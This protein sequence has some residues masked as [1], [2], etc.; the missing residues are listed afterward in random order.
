M[1]FRSTAA[2]DSSRKLLAAFVFV[3]IFAATAYEF[4]ELV[5]A[6]DLMGFAYVGLLAVGS[7]FVIAILNNWRNGVYLFFSWLL[8]EDLA[9][10]YLGNNMAIYFAK[11][12]LVAVVYLSFIIAVRRKKTIKIVRPPFFVAVMLL[13]WFGIMQMFNPASSTIVYG[14]LGVKLFFWYIPLYFVG[15]ALLNS[16][17]DLRRFFR[18]NAWLALIITGLGVAQS[19]IGPSF[20]NPA[21]PAEE[22]REL[23]TLYRVSPITGLSSYR[24]PSV[25]VS[26]GRYT[27][28]LLIAW[29]LMLAF[30]GY[31][32]LR[33]RRGR[34]IAFISL[35]VV[36]AA[37]LLSGSRGVF[38]WTAGEALFIVAAYLWGAPWRQREVIRVFR[39]VQ[40]A[41]L[42]IGLAVVALFF[43]FPDALFARLAIYSETLTPGSSASELQSRTWDYP[44]RNF[45]GAFNYDRWPYG[46]GIG[47][48]SL[49]VQYVAKIFHGAPMGVGV[50]SGFGALVV[51]MGI[52]GLILW[53]VMSIAI[54]VSAW[55][56][57][58]KLKGTP[59]FPIAFAIF[60]YAF[61][62][63]LPITFTSMVA[64]EDFVIN[65][66][67]WT[68][69]GILFRLPSLA[70][71][72]QFANVPAPA[73]NPRLRPR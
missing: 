3:L 48:S 45:L 44:L 73:A 11:D 37:V 10:K 36:Y 24:A 67:F 40:R 21:R 2:P 50:E 30:T 27:N 19:I 20:L 13:V 8:F 7:V 47:T 70:L 25:F 65:A 63:L 5:L 52:G 69:L 23:S 57:V 14:I 15:Y 53:L 55:K 26:A 17:A 42:A 43:V 58:K 62:L 6:G 72:T 39:T 61:V 64:Y 46:F 56:I 22:I 32:L 12:V 41:A 51:E 1:N 35:A 66:Y 60:L 28:Y 18:F 33:H 16:E 54:L 68:L 31:L 4:S 71:S 49:G 38:L 59:W 29:V 9:R 34:N